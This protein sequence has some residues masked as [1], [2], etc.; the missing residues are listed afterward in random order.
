MTPVVLF[1]HVQNTLTEYVSIS[2]VGAILISCAQS[3]QILSLFCVVVGYA[4][5]L[6]FSF[7]VLYLYLIPRRPSIIHYHSW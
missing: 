4:F 3:F 1:A 6:T 5:I 7:L 2:Y